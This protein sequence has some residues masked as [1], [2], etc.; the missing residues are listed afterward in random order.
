MSDLLKESTIILENERVLIRPLSLSDH[1][2]LLPFS[3]NEPE[4]WHFSL[5]SAAGSENLTLYIKTALEEREKGLSYPFII[6]DKLTKTYAGST[7]YYDIQQRFQTL[8]LGYTWYGG[9]FQGT[10]LNK[11]CKYLLLKYAFE[12]L[13]IERV[14]FRADNTNHRS[15]AAM[16]SI[17]C[18]M[19][20]V[21]RNHLPNGHG[22][23]RDSIILSILKAEWFDTVKSN[24]AEK[25]SPADQH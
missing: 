9:D 19:E 16:K 14:E 15:I 22:G 18:K 17:G 1:E 12:D 13:G 2:H 3:L 25:I 7:R 8:Q 5:L 23:R 20:G 11:N 10:G 21:L 24:L 6:Y 4:I